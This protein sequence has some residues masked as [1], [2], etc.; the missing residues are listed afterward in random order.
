MGNTNFHSVSKEQIIISKYFFSSLHIKLF[1]LQVEFANVVI[2]NKTDLMKTED[3]IKIRKLIKEM[4]PH[5]SI[6]ECSYGKIPCKA[7]LSTGAFE[8][9]EAQKHEMWLKEART[10]EHKPESE[11]YGVGSFVFKARRPFH[12]QR[13]WN[14]MKDIENKKEPYESVVRGKGM[15][16]LCTRHYQGGVLSVAGRVA[17]L[18]PGPMW[19]DCVDRCEWPEG[20][21]KEMDTLWDAEHGDRQQVSCIS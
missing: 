18:A 20:L 17:E 9:A 1:G 19:W 6:V 12:P 4:N 11:E 7:V 3:K 5:G 15:A 14:A 13:L 8:L 16:W 10:G 21:E 2:L